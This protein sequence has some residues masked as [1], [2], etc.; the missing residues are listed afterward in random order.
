MT[1]DQYRQKESVGA[2]IDLRGDVNPASTVLS[3][4]DYAVA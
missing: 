4:R 1:C 2:T 3:K